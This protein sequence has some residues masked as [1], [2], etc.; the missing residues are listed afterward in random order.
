MPWSHTD[1]GRAI[2][3][4]PGGEDVESPSSRP[5]GSLSYW[6]LPMAAVTQ[7]PFS[8][9]NQIHKRYSCL[10]ICESFQRIIENE[11]GLGNAPKLGIGV[12]SQGSFG[13]CV[14]DIGPKLLT[15]VEIKR[16]K[17]KRERE[18]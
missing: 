5:P 12:R 2:Q 10:R 9:I 1:V 17:K 3:L 13:Y 7:Q 15:D 8:V 14:L 11:G 18:Q 4:D 6:L 16:Q